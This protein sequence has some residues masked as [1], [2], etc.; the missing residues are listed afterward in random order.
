VTTNAARAAILERSLRASI[1]GDSGAVK[2]LYTDDIK[3]W[4]PALSAS[5]AAEL[6]AEFDRR[7]DAFSDIALEVRPLDVGGDFA[8]VEWTVTMTH[9]GPLTLADGV[10]VEPSGLT[11]S[12]NGTTVAEFEGERICSFRQYWDELT[13][14][15]QLG[16][17]G[18]PQ[19]PASN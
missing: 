2:E 9:S 7:D 1:Q 8:C 19:P 12:I 5:S 14:L 16:L 4:A 11:V 18:E 17:L 10:V 15:E 6:A 13:V 3:A